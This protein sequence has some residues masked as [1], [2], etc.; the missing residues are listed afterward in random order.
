MFM[1]NLF[2]SAGQGLG[3]MFGAFQRER[4]R[5]RQPM[6]QEPMQQ[7]QAP[8]SPFPE[9]RPSAQ[10]ASQVVSDARTFLDYSNPNRGRNAYEQYLRELERGS[11]GEGVFAARDYTRNQLR[12]YDKRVRLGMPL[13][14]VRKQQDEE[15][16]MRGYQDNLEGQVVGQIFRGLF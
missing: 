8:A 1:G 10:A 15:E 5:P 9:R 14:R 16:K 3:E 6:E 2:S 13:A 7:E 12:D 4:Q 11:S